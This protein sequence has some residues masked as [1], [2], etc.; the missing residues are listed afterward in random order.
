VPGHILAIGGGGGFDELLLS[1]ASSSRPRV[2]YLATAVGDDAGHIVDFYERFEGLSCAPYHVRLFGMP[3]RPADRVARAD[4]VLVN[5]GNT[6]N[7]LALWRVH[8]LDDALRAAWEGGAVLGGASAGANCWFQGCVTDSF[9][10]ELE[11]LAD[12][13][14]VLRGSFCPHYDGEELR[15]PAY[16]RLVQEGALPAGLACD[17]FAAAV[18]EGTDLVEIVAT[19]EGA[20]AYRV[21]ATGET[22]LPARLI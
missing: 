17:D 14:G 13:L 18:F 6:A 3:E 1:L 19:R 8:G 9:G 11:P 12:G 5:G 15:R 4:V 20:A 2:C 16:T 10:P 7:L 22:P 21:D